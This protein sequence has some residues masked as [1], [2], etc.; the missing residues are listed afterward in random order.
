MLIYGHRGASACC[1]ENSEASLRAAITRAH[2]CEF[3]LR[4]TADNQ[5]IVLHDATLLRTGT[6]SAGQ[7]K[8]SNENT[9]RAPVCS[10]DLKTDV[11]QLT[12]A[13]LKNIDIGTWKG[14]EWRGERILTLQ[15]ALRIVPV[16][17]GILAELKGN[18][19]AVSDILRGMISMNN[20][21]LRPSQTPRSGP[22]D[23]RLSPSAKISWA[24]KC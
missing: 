23:E 2:G 7:D 13:R 4:V 3:D 11:S 6:L 19:I 24:L 15:E 22:G 10:W 12:L 5:I 21:A 1:P 8:D 9:S 14:H 18:G 17:K 16:E 20:L